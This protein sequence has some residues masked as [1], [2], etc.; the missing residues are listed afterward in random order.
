MQQGN[1]NERLGIAI[2]IQLPTTRYNDRET[3]AQ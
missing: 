2:Y 3:E 1:T